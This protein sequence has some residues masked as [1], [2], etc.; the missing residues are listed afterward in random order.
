M[1]QVDFQ[2]SLEFAVVLDIV[3]GLR[4]NSSPTYPQMR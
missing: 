2:C 4:Y 1:K 3:V